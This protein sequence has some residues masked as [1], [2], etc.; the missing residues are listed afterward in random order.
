[1]ESYHAS[2]GG[3]P[4]LAAF[5]AEARKQSRQNWRD[6]YTAG[7]VINYLRQQLD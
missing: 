1:M 4:M 7:P 2:M 3:A 6:E 5:L